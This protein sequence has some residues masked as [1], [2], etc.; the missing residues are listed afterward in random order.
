[1]LYK[2][3]LDVTRGGFFRFPQLSLF[4]VVLGYDWFILRDWSEIKGHIPHRSIVPPFWFSIGTYKVLEGKS[5]NASSLSE[6]G[7]R[8]SHWIYRTL[9]RL[10]VFLKET[11]TTNKQLWGFKGTIPTDLLSQRHYTWKLY[12]GTAMLPEANCDWLCPSPFTHRGILK[13]PG[14]NV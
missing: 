1:M 10:S 4:E 14:E 2:C 13:E 12:R 6:R 9:S 3:Y 11:A 5:H 7:E 8:K